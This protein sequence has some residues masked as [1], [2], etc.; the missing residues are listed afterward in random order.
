M[1]S[2]DWQT[3]TITDKTSYRYLKI[4]N[5]SS[6]FLNMAEIKFY[7][8]LRQ[9]GVLYPNDLQDQVCVAQ[10]IV[11]KGQANYSD[12]TWQAL[13]SALADGQEAISRLESGTVAQ[14]ELDA[15]T[16][17]LKAALSALKQ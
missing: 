5:D 6:C 17:A 8:K 1:N 2:A 11:N 16:T 14:D 9:A 13:E 12:E 3:L 10:S 15:L 7:G 4:I